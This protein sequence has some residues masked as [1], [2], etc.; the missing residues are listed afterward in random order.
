MCDTVLL[1]AGGASL[2][3]KNSDRPDA[4]AQVVEVHPRRG[5]GG[6]VA[7]QYLVLDDPGAAAV[8][9]SRPT[10]LWGAEHGCNE[11]GVAIG[12]EKVAALGP[13]GAAPGVEPG[14]IGMDLV[15]LGLERGAS[16]VQ[17]VEVITALVERHGQG[18]VCDL[19]TGEGYS[20]SF[21]VADAKEAYVVETSGRTWAARREVGSAAISNRLCLG[22][23][24]DLAS[25]DVAPG[26]DFDDR[27]DHVVPTDHADTRLAASRRFLGRAGGSA[28]A[29]GT[30]APAAPDRAALAAE[31]VGHLR[32]HGDGPW[33]SPSAR[34]SISSVPTEVTAEGK[35]TTICMHTRGSAATAAG[36]IVDLDRRDS[37]GYR[38]AAA[39]GSPC[40]GVFVPVEV[41][42]ELPAVLGDERVWRQFAELRGRAERH[43][44]ELAAIRAV[45]DPVEDELWALEGVWPERAD[46]GTSA[47]IADRLV[48]AALGALGASGA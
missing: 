3:A 12:N 16:A 43:L 36:M 22:R 17:A 44:D 35:G 41:P 30:G 4:E 2:F 40:V 34:G 18:G 23:H 7:T 47:M 42:G 6:Q 14:L 29:A 5:G 31:M 1:R 8:V 32:D 46:A 45:L 20:S 25:A 10:W 28:V 9:I 26:S 11:H 33:G 13:S 38:F 48:R 21:L 37:G 24:F 15:R 39:L 27:R 19:V